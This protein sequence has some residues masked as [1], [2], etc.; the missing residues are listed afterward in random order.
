MQQTISHVAA[1]WVGIELAIHQTVTLLALGNLEKGSLEEELNRRWQVRFWPA[2]GSMAARV[3]N[4]VWKIIAA[5]APSE[6]I[7]LE[8]VVHPTVCRHELLHGFGK[9]LIDRFVLG[10]LSFIFHITKTNI[11]TRVVAER[12]LVQ[13]YCSFYI[14]YSGV[15]SNSRPLVPVEKAYGVLD[16]THRTHCSS[17]SNNN[18]RP[19]LNGRWLC[20]L[21]NLK[22]PGGTD[23][24]SGRD[25]RDLCS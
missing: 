4:R 9:Y 19:H 8:F 12:A 13:S 11:R 2:E 6:G 23:A 15:N 22:E 16:N 24:H 5:H 21:V 20:L 3:R 14:S 10:H 1:L 25:S 7:K 18:N 17:S